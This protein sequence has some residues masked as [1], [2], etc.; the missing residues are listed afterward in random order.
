ML[1]ITAAGGLGMTY[2]LFH[3][4]YKNLSSTYLEAAKIDGAGHYAIFFRIILPQTLPL[5]GALFLL[6]WIADWNSYGTALIYL[7]KIPTLG[8]GLY[9]FEQDMIYHVR[10]DILYAAC[11]LACIPTL[12]LFILFNNVLM[13]NVSLGGIK[14]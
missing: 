10:S 2:M 8:V 9:L 5:F 3:A 12:T 6:T 14:E 1:I 13:S 4:Y 11:M 7:P